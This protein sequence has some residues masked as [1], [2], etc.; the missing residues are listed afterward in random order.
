MTSTA[1]CGSTCIFTTAISDDAEGD[2]LGRVHGRS[3]R[4]R[5]KSS[6]KAGQRVVVPFTISCGSCY[7]CSKTQY[8]A[9]RMRTRP[10]PGYRREGYGHPMP[11]LFGYS[12]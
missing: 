4:G 7:H 1:I 11:G 12:T 3:R 6:L 2:I 9:A 5:A 8:S 10:T